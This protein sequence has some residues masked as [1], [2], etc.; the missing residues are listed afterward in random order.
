MNSNKTRDSGSPEA[1]ADRMMKGWS[2]GDASDFLGL[3]PEEDRQVDLG[4][5]ISNAVRAAR[6][7]VGL[8][9]QQLAKRIGSSQPRVVRIECGMAGVS[10][11]LGFRALFSMGGTLA[12]VA[13]ELAVI[14][15]GKDEL[16]SRIDAAKAIVKKRAAKAQSVPTN[17]AKSSTAASK[18]RSSAT[19]AGN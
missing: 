18:V 17:K 5:A 16:R 8:T 4:G 15:Q 11:D 1:M 10:F 13:S 9:Q 12:D 6:K 19:A 2:V 7:K 14:E 3:T